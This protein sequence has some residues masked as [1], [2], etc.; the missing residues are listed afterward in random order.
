MTVLIGQAQGT[1]PTNQNQDFGLLYGINFCE[2]YG[3]MNLYN[4]QTNI[5]QLRFIL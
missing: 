4:R 5:Y 3:L 2:I 1:V